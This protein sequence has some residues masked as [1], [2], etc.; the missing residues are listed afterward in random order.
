MP[1]D[2]HGKLAGILDRLNALVDSG[3]T[4]V[5]I[6]PVYARAAGAG[7]L[8][9]A[10]FSPDPAMSSQGPALAATELKQVI[11]ACHT[12]GLEVLVSLDFGVTAEEF[13]PMSGALQGMSGINRA[14][15]YRQ[16]CKSN[17]LRR[18]LLCHLA[19]IVLLHRKSSNLY[20]TFHSLFYEGV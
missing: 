18:S 1:A 11:R 15:Y 20:T 4:S 7:R 3:V 10:L 5:I 14:I 19:A 8:P 2:R 13:E 12:V 16:V 17:F 9:M 6:N